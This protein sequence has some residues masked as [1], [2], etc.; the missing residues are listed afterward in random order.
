MRLR[1]GALALAAEVSRAAERTDAARTLLLDLDGTLAPIAPAPRLARVP[2]PTRDALR[3]LARSGWTLAVVTG[4]PGAEARRLLALRGVAVLGSHGASGRLARGPSRVLARIAARARSISRRT[5]GSL[6]ER[7]PHGLAFHE[8]GVARARRAAWRRAVRAILASEDLAGLE[9][10]RGRSVTELRARGAH[11]GRAL[12]RVAG[13][14][15][16]PAPRTLDASLVALG[17][18]RTHEDLFAAIRG[19]GL[20]VRVGRR[21][22][23]TGATR[24][25][26]SPAAVRRFLAALASREAGRGA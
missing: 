2:E 14:R 26:A 1:D 12:E 4:R 22:V 17:D 24:R 21:G 13:P 15:P 3:A 9:V 6:V 10:L 18:D 16:T 7:K 11:K 23:R 8:R 20:G 19:R 25:L 5:P